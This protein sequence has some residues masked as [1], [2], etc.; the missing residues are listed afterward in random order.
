M[1]TCEAVSYGLFFD[2]EGG[3]SIGVAVNTSTGALVQSVPELHSVFDCSNDAPRVLCVPGAEAQVLLAGSPF[4]NQ[5]NLQLAGLSEQPIWR[6]SWDSF[7]CSEDDPGL[8]AVGL[9]GQM[10]AVACNNRGN[11]RKISGV[12]LSDGTTRWERSGAEEVLLTPNMEQQQQSGLFTMAGCRLSALNESTGQTRWEYKGADPDGCAFSDGLLVVGEP[13]VVLGWQQQHSAVTFLA[14]DGADG[15]QLWQERVELLASRVKFVSASV[16]VAM[17][18]AQDSGSIFLVG[19]DLLSTGGESA[20]T[21]QQVNTTGPFLGG[22]GGS[23]LQQT[24]DHGAISY[25][26]SRT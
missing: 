19:V 26:F 4:I 22:G 5:T 25:V 10:A 8:V 20:V 1:A 21:V 14:L 13:P 6:R 18:S 12:S 17:L 15:T 23:V 11:N 24:E 9:A 7:G 3:C 16:D 2:E